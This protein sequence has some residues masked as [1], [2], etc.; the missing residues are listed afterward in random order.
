MNILEGALLIFMCAILNHIRGGGFGSDAL[1]KPHPRFYVA[2][3]MGLLAANGP[4]TM[5]CV[6]IGFLIWSWLPWGRWADLGR[7]A[8]G[9]PDYR[10]YSKFETLV[11][12]Y[13]PKSD[14]V[15][16]GVRHLIALLPLAATVNP[17]FG[18]MAPLFVISYELGWRFFPNMPYRVGEFLSGAVWGLFIWMLL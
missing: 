3:L 16:L 10:P 1:L 11:E 5:V 14:Y 9:Y 18:L 12:R 2:P 7:F 8:E 15:R 6:S 13:T 4:Y 17:L